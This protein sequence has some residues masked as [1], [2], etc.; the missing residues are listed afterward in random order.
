MVHFLQ[1]MYGTYIRLT[2]HV[3]SSVVTRDTEARENQ[4]VC[5]FTYQYVKCNKVIQDT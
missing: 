2:I 4:P 5:T 1:D 3:P